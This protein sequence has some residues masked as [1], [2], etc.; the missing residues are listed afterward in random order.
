[1][2]D[3]H[4]ESRNDDT[5]HYQELHDVHGATERKGANL[6]YLTVCANNWSNEFNYLVFS[7]AVCS[8]S[9]NIFRVEISCGWRADDVQTMCRRCADDVWMTWEQD[10]GRDFTGG[11]RMSSTCHPHVVR[12][13][14][15]HHADDKRQQLCTKPTGFLVNVKC[16]N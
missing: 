1:M 13:L 15:A 14:S 10:F 6:P 8:L 16:D 3:A 9:G 2:L 12:M 5:E 7:R 4:T 11:W